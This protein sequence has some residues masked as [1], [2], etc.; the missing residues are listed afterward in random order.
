MDTHGPVAFMSDRCLGEGDSYLSK[1]ILDAVRCSSQLT[2]DF[3][4]QMQELTKDTDTRF[5]IVSDHLAHLNNLHKVLDQDV[6]RNTAI[7]IGKDAPPRVVNTHGAMFDVFPTLLDWLGWSTGD[8]A[9]IGVSMLS[10]TPTLTEV[11]GAK[12]VDARL[13]VDLPL[14]NVIWNKEAD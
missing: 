4:E 14:S 9:G 8:V 1:D 7:F 5:V 11:H 12:D 2:L 6:R 13:K 3:V 10:D